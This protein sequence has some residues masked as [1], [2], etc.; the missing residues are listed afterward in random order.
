MAERAEVAI[1]GG[2][3]MGTSLA[4]ALTRLGVRDVLLLERGTLAAGASGKTGALLRQHYTN[5]PEATLAHRSLQIFAH[6]AD[7]VGGDCGFAPAGSIITVATRGADAVNVARMRRNVAL[8]NSLGV[9]AE[10]IAPDRLRELQPF[11]VAEDIDAAVYEPESGYVD[12]VAATRGMAEAALRGGARLRERC[13][14]TG[15]RAQ[16]GRVV[17]LETE[18]GPVEAG[19]VVVAGGAWS[20]P[21]LAALGVEVP[22]QAQRVQVVVLNR[23][24][25]MPESGT[26]C[27]VDTAAGFF[28]RDAGPNRTLAGVGGG[29]F[30]DVV[31][32]FAYDERLNPGFGETVKRFMARRMPAMAEASTLYGYA[33]L[34]DLS[35]DAHPILG[36]VEGY[37]N[38]HLMLGFSGAG[39]KKGPA[40]GQALAELIVHG[41]ASFVDLTPFRL[42]RFQDE[43]W[44]A[45]W[46]PDEYSFSTDFGH[47]F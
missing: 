29:E 31:D 4:F 14:V 6:W 37:D 41:K 28:C 38:L 5:V 34:Y 43:A 25:A 36:G 10:V 7:V 12:A 24:L 33:C 39:F 15:L 13:A 22:L 46:S 35:P 21:L 26:M 16:D 45:P 1:V 3:I 8:L 27:Y 11:T 17:G 44:R 47:K 30:H 2:G 20:L 9:K 18:A 32:P 23:P 40:T 19:T 42:S